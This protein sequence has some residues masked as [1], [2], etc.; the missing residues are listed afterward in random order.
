MASRGA[1]QR[2]PL[3][4]SGDTQGRSRCVATSAAWKMGADCR[5]AGVV[6]KVARDGRSAA[7]LGERRR[8]AAVPFH[9]TE[10]WVDGISDT[11]RVDGN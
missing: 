3:A 9:G 2:M 1:A 10:P 7:V 6:W 11:D 5:A 8:E 4:V